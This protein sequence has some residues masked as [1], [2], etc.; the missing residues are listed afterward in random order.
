MDLVIAAHITERRT[1]KQHVLLIKE[2]NA[3]FT[4]AKGTEPQSNQTSAP[5]TKMW[6]IQRTKEYSKLQVKWTSFFKN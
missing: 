3:I 1:T 5:A 4:V 6:E 2:H